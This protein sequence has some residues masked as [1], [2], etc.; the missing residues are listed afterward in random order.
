M[1][2]WHILPSLKGGG[3][4]KLVCSLHE[5]MCREGIDSYLINFTDDESGSH[6]KTINLRC[7]NPYHPLV[8]VRLSALLR[9]RIKK[10]VGPDIIHTHLTP[11]QFFTPLCCQISGSRVLLVTTEH[12]TFNKRRKMHFGQMFDRL[13][14][15]FYS[16]VICI[17]HGTKHSLETWQPSLAD[18]LIT[19]YNGINLDK[20]WTVPKN[21]NA[22]DPIIIISVGRLVSLKNYKTALQAIS[23]LHD[24][25]FEYHIVGTGPEKKYL[26]EIVSD[27]KLNH[28]VKFLGWS[29]DV[30]ALLQQSDIFLL[31][32]R[33]EGF[34]LSM[35]EAMATA[36]PLVVS[37]LAGIREVSGSDGECGYLVNPDD[38][39]GIAER[40]RYLCCNEQMRISLGASGQ[41]RVKKFSIE[42]TLGRHIALYRE[43]SKTQGTFH[44]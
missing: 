44:P 3:A 30:S 42:K 39:D 32:S 12:S 43:L 2:V 15:H 4:E 25:K 16:S 23:K 21:K 28:C 13:L 29:D 34:G 20:F 22:E 19:I 38:V 37:D 36:L 14:Y 24:L 8:I 7:K 17:S 41:K 31:T 5:R 33:W 6:D 9:D 1:R 18:K 11:C 35:A 26:Q 40:L 10:G 27:L